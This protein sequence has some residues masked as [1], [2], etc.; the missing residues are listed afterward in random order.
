MRITQHSSTRS[1]SRRPHICHNDRSPA[2]QEQ[3]NNNKTN[4]NK[5][6]KTN[7]HSQK[8]TTTTKQNGVECEK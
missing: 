1:F 5:E 2:A 3:Q 6:H 7:K 8:D 4:N